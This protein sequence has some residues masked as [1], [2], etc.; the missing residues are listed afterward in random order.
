[1]MTLNG[2]IDRQPHPI[3][4]ED[5]VARLDGRWLPLS[6][7]AWAGVAVVAAVV[8]VTSIPNYVRLVGVVTE[9]EQVMGRL[10]GG[11]AMLS[12]SPGFEFWVDVI[13]N[14]LSFCASILSLVLA[15]LIYRKKPDDRMAVVTSLTLLIFGV[16]MAGP[17]EMLVGQRL[18]SE[19][20]VLS[21]QMLLWGFVLFLFYIFPDGHFLPRWT[22]WLAI[23]LVP[24][25]VALSIWQ[26]LYTDS[27]RMGIF[28]MLYI[29]PSIT[30]PIA[31]IYRYRRASSGI[32]RQQTKWAI[33]GF[34][35]WI[36][37]GT[38]VPGLFITLSSLLFTAN[39]PVTGWAEIFIFAGRIVW[40]L[41]L[42]IVP[43][44]LTVAVL[45][46]RLFNID[47][48]LNRA[49]V[50]GILTAFVILAYLL[51]VTGFSLI[52]QA[53]GNLVPFLLATIVILLLLR[54]LHTR[55]QLFANR[56]IQ[57]PQRD[58]L[59][60]KKRTSGIDS[61]PKQE[62]KTLL[63]VAHILWFITATIAILVIGLSI[64]GYGKLINSNTIGVPVNASPGY[65]AVLQATSTFASMTAALVAFSLAVI[66]F[67]RKRSETMALF[68]SW[69]LLIYSIVMAGPLE[70]FLKVVPVGPLNLVYQ[71]Q[72]LL[73]G[74]P[75]LLLFALFP[76]GRFVPS[77]T[78]WVV[79]AS[80]PL[81]PAML[82]LTPNAWVSFTEPVSV[83]AA[84]L[85]ILLFA[86]GGLYAQ[87]YRYRWV[88]NVIERQQTKW[89]VFGLVL[90]ILL[91]I[92]SSIG[93]SRLQNLQAGA[94]LPWWIPLT[95]LSWSVLLTL[96]PACLAIAVLRF[97]LWD[98]NILLN[99]TLVFGTLTTLVAGLFILV[100]TLLGAVFNTSDNLF[101]SLLATA[102]IAILF[103][104]LREGLQRGVNRMMYGERDD[105]YA[106]LS[107][108]GKRMEAIIAPEA[109]MPAIA[110]T[111]AETLKFP[112][113]AI[114]FQNGEGE[115]IIAAHG[116]AV[117]VD[118]RL[119]LVYQ[120]ETIGQLIVAPRSRGEGFSPAELR[121]LED[122]AHQAGAA[123]YAV[124]VTADLQHSREKLVL[125]REEERRRL[126]RDLH[127]GLG[128][129]LAALNLQ[130]GS[131]RNSIT[132]NDTADLLIGEMRGEIHQAI[133]DIRQ[134]AYN[135]RP[136]ALDELGLLAS[137]QEQAARYERAGLQVS[138]EAPDQLPALPAAVEVAIYRIVQE[139]L[140][141]VAHHAH[142]HRCSVH[143]ELNQDIGLKVIDDGTGIL[144]EHKAGV[145]LFSMRE[146]AAE[147]GG[148]CS[149]E[150]TGSGTCV[151]VHIPW[152]KE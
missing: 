79:L 71:F 120:S 137:L 18:S 145:G 136:P 37:G 86:C 74:S 14:L 12:T 82:W 8:L 104:P 34:T 13:Y 139:A 143:L 130:M 6:R 15:W 112:Y 75:S 40:P 125:A 19:S 27:S 105:P 95:Q 88:S 55:L 30:A 51:I 108:L 127:D 94:S 28:M 121:L 133:T 138:L 26:P 67:W 119:P 76:N 152:M 21:G 39:T 23:F 117:D 17:L 64:P 25:T 90:T 42:A 102:T 128:A 61:G 29:L 58:E 93:F 3:S 1:M 57:V 31:Q 98:V 115:E 54:P 32:Q 81:F 77:W 35:T 46:H 146:R 45:R 147:L 11:S 123:A 83:V 131:L 69:Y 62:K 126:R 36:L 109:V 142:A 73:M 70:A 91:G 47:I 111:I 38:V 89:F 99:R 44:S 16:V 41:S 97:H 33:F 118:T 72:N 53:N 63:F 114:A 122:I 92:P 150:S 68:V 85:S 5:N 24:W 149:V 78:R 124:R 20:I 116:V 103:Q 80:L 144:P 148:T 10:M 84:V 140:A 107:R 110:E 135:L 49:L 87:I 134:L 113:V 56:V 50:Y 141:N 43:I 9:Q 4:G 59:Q 132:G 2:T 101:I 52:S 96:I 151:Q 60:E 100:V 129:T 65:V 66:L 106:V 48:I 22:R 7:A